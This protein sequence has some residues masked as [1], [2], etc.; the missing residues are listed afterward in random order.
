MQPY[1]CCSSNLVYTVGL[2]LW[3]TSLLKAIDWQT[4]KLLA[5]YGT[6]HPWA[7]VDRLYFPRKIGGRGL[8]SIEDTIM[9]DLCNISAYFK[10]DKA[11]IDAGGQSIWSYLRPQD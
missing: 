6:H 8:K 5:F 10:K 11:A 2:I 7:D 4:R 3:P 9:E 1:L